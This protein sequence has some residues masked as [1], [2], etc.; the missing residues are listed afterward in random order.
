MG[1]C[2]PQVNK[3]VVARRKELVLRGVGGQCPNLVHVAGHNLLDVELKGALEDRVPG[4]A[5]QQL[6]AFT[7]GYRSDGSKVLGKLKLFT[8]FYPAL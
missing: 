1:E 5:K 7:L 6:T 2:V 4:G 8:I 3:L